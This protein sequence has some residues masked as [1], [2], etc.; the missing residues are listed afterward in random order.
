MEG[1]VDLVSRSHGM[2]CEYGNFGQYLSLAHKSSLLMGW[3]LFGVSFVYKDIALWLVMKTLL[4]LQFVVWV[5]QIFFQ[6]LRHDP[7]CHDQIVY[8][9]PNMEIT[10]VWAL[11]TIFIFH[12][13]MWKWRISWFCWV[14]VLTWLLGPVGVIIWTDHLV[15]WEIL[16]S[17]GFAI[18]FSIV[19]VFV[20]RDHICPIL[21][22]LLTTWPISWLGY[23]DIG[24]C[25]NKRQKRKLEYLTR[26]KNRWRGQLHSQ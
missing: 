23:K 13:W 18:L 19:Y 24:G 5:F 1:L 3:V 21:P 16:V 7:W 14:L 6:D 11:G 2:V 15:W 17:I 20:F 25:L 8:A 4:I 9:L 12:Y 22:H 10:Y 26:V